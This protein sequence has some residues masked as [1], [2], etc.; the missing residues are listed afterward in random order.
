MTLP[1]L[2]SS[3]KR[4]VDPGLAISASASQSLAH[5]WKMFSI[6]ERLKGPP[7]ALK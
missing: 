1:L 3:T 2:L 6:S 4:L 7:A 5:F